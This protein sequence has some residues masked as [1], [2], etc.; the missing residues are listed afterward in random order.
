[1]KVLPLGLD[2]RSRVHIDRPH[3]LLVLHVL[4]YLQHQVQAIT[5]KQLAA[6]RTS[7]SSDVRL[8]RNKQKM[9][10]ICNFNVNAICW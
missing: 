6:S 7:E 9:A 1:M 4:G 10:E 3:L 2:R 5:V 8:V